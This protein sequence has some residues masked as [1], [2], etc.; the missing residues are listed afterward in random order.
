MVRII[1]RRGDA[2]PG[3]SV[4]QLRVWKL[5]EQDVRACLIPIDAIMDKS[6]ML[7]IS[8]PAAEAFLDAISQCEKE[9]VATLWVHDPI[10][11][12]PPHAR[13]ARETR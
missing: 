13:P 7:E 5:S 6:A 11:L 2:V 10:G 1:D 9:G 3:E 8:D 4:A 12:F